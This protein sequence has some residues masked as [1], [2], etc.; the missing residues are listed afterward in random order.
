MGEGFDDFLAQFDRL[1]RQLRRDLRIPG[2]REGVLRKA[3]AALAMIR[4]YSPADEGEEIL[5]EVAAEEFDAII[6]EASGG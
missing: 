2:G 5:L 3:R 6:S 1:R 4:T